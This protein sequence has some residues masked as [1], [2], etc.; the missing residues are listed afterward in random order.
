M[1]SG[2]VSHHCEATEHEQARRVA[3]PAW[4]RGLDVFL[5]LLSSP[6]SLLIGALI[7][8]FVKLFSR[9][10]IL[11]QQDRIG[12]HG[13]PFRMVKFR[14]M[15]TDADPAQHRDYLKN[16]IQSDTPMTKMDLKGDPRLILGGALL[17][18]T[19]LDELPQLLNVLRGDMSLVGPR[20][21]L[22]YELASYS[23]EQKHRFDVLP[24]LTGWWQV[25]GK[26]RTS[27]TE[28]IQ[29]DIWY[30]RN[31]SPWLDLKI[32]V[33]TIPALLAQVF[34]TWTGSRAK[35]LR[36]PEKSPALVQN[37]ESTYE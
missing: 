11:F 7:A 13:R 28:M 8:L 17:R 21:C 9:G 33:L 25:R 6:V 29:L 4:K 16:L 26:N 10:P 24:G 36:P 3:C 1:E 27:F 20:P 30:T 34:D 37:Q 5:V 22:P 12:F 31:K 2:A 14:T 19:G 32:I 23:P 35:R 15:K 18:A